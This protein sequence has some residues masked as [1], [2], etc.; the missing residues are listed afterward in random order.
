MASEKSAFIF[1]SMLVIL[2]QAIIVKFSLN[3]WVQFVIPFAYSI[4]FVICFF[5]VFKSDNLIAFVT[6]LL[7]G[8]IT[9]MA[10][11]NHTTSIY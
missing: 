9:L 4:I 1:V 11:A 3:T 5:F 2:A 6:L 10:T 7:A 8:N